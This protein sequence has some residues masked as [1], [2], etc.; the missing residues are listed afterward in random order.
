MVSPNK[1]AWLTNKNDFCN[2][3]QRKRQNEVSQKGKFMGQAVVRI[4]K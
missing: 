3:N 2:I 4:G 1:Q